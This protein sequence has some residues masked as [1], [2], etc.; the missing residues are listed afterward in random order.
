MCGIE[1]VCS[2][3]SSFVD[4][5]IDLIRVQWQSLLALVSVRRTSTVFA[6]SIPRGFVCLRVDVRGNVD[7]IRQLANANFEP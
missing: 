6:P 7:R 1:N 2:R 4:L 5:C 3:E